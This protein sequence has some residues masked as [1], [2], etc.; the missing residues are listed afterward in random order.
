[1][2]LKKNKKKNENKSNLIKLINKVS[3]LMASFNHVHQNYQ[4]ILE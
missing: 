2:R 1:M 3:P 4:Y